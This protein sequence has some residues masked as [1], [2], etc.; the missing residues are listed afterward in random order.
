MN[1]TEP[2]PENIID[3]ISVT[4]KPLYAESSIKLSNRRNDDETD[5]ETDEEATETDEEEDDGEE[6]EEVKEKTP[7]EV[8]EKTPTE[9][10]FEYYKLKELWDESVKKYL[11]NTKNKDKKDK[12]RDLPCVNCKQ[13]GGT[14]FSNVNGL[15]KATCGNISTP[16]V[17]N[18]Q[19]QKGKIVQLRDL[20]YD[21]HKKINEY[22]NNMI[23]LKL[24]LIFGYS[25]EET[26]IENFK[27]N[28][29]LLKEHE[30]LL[31]ECHHYLLNMTEKKDKLL[32]EYNTQIEEHI[33]NIKELIDTFKEKKEE[34]NIQD[35][36]NEYIEKVYPLLE[37]IR[38][39]KYNVLDM[40]C[41]DLSE[42]N[43]K[44]CSASKLIQ[45]KFKVEETE[46]YIGDKME[47]ISYV[48]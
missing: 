45:D 23:T 48:R 34:Q 46:M 1:N 13:L 2:E 10:A 33:Q 38:N 28:N 32:S 6:E 36:V 15:L 19:I 20:E 17:L 21:L 27:N 3:S 47:V 9:V 39:T 7:V 5:E 8:K 37:K 29:N 16:C 43:I 30:R 31:Y 18:I 4:D 14:L 35:I 44:K 12:Y 24:D 22:K 26:T 40:E 11:I 25:D 42:D 41:E